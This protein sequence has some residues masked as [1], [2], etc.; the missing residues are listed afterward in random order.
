[1]PHAYKEPNAEV[2]QLAGT[3]LSISHKYRARLSIRIY[4]R[5]FAFVDKV[6][7]VFIGLS[8]F[9]IIALIRFFLG[10]FFNIVNSVAAVF[11]IQN[12]IECGGEKNHA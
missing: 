9:I 6:Y 2:I 10:G 8:L 4:L 7:T 11:P 12:R 1:M 5:R 3:R